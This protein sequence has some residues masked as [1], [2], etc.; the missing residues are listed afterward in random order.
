MKSTTRTTCAF[1]LALALAA[2]PL[3][4]CGQKG[5]SEAADD[6]AQQEQAVSDLSA[7]DDGIEDAEGEA[8]ATIGDDTG[9]ID[10]GDFTVRIPAYWV[11]RVDC[12]IEKSSDGTTSAYLTLP[13]NPEAILA[14]FFFVEGDQSEIAGDIAYHLTKQVTDGNGHHVECWT[15]NWPWLAASA[16]AG[17]DMDLN[18]DKD[19]LVQLVDLSTG[20]K[21]SYDDACSAGPDSIAWA[22]SEYTAEAFASAISFD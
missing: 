22:E 20:G 13:G 7:Q 12:K 4:G 2:A 10:A 14:S 21:V 6:A 18:V 1:A 8:S 11:D 15:S 5:E 3:A 19:S 9:T 17:E 16:A